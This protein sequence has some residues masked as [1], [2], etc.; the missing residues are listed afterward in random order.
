MGEDSLRDFPT[1]HDPERVVRAAE[2]AVAGRP[3][4]DADLAVVGRAVPGIAG[5]VHVVPVAELDISASEIRRRVQ[6]GESISG[7][8]SPAVEAY[9]Q[10]RGLYRSPPAS[11]PAVT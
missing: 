7:L 8:V 10:V 6:D 2:L 1:W 11:P 3:G 9:I 4:V 5:R